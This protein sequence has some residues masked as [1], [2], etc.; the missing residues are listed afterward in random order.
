M[1]SEHRSS[2]SA[3]DRPFERSYWVVERKL[4][5]GCYPGSPDNVE[6]RRKLARMPDLGITHFVSLME[7]EELDHDGNPLQPYEAEAGE[8][9]RERQL[10]VSFSRFPI[11]DVD[12]PTRQTMTR[13]LD[14]IDRAIEGGKTVYVHCWGGCGRTGLVI[15]CWLAR[16]GLARGE[17]ALERLAELRQVIPA[18]A[19]GSSPETSAQ[20]KMVRE[21]QE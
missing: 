8:L 20:K 14:D 4:I 18:G 21:W 11:R 2:A 17:R 13:A 12:V 7:Q 3:P 6:M 5:A 19:R 15:G 9:A 16:H 10:S 1:N